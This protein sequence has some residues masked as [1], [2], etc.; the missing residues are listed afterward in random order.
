MSTDLYLLA[1]EAPGIL[2][3]WTGP[4]EYDGNRTVYDDGTFYVGNDDGGYPEWCAHI[5]DD[6]HLDFRLPEVR[7]RAVRWL[8]AHLL[9]P[10]YECQTVSGVAENL[11]DD[12]AAL[13]AEVRAVAAAMKEP[14]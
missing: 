14:R 1:S 7:D 11:R 2:D 9:P 5:T 4:V 3:G 13:L 6:L 12:P 10:R 8:E